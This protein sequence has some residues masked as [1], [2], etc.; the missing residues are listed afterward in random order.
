MLELLRFLKRMLWSDAGEAGT[1]RFAAAICLGLEVETDSEISLY[2]D[3]IDE[4]FAMIDWIS[5]LG[6]VKS[7]VLCLP[8]EPT[9]ELIRRVERVRRRLRVRRVTLAVD[10]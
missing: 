5:R 1:D 2:S 4:A 3:S 7:I 8:G 10:P 9:A 6:T